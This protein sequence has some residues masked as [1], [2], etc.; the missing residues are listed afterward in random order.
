L[1]YIQNNR[2]NEHK[3]L[4][5]PKEALNFIVNNWENNLLSFSVFHRTRKIENAHFQEKKHLI[6]NL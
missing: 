1:A 4:D 2:R 5:K 3:K 6:F